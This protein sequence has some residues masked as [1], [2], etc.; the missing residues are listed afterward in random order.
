MLNRV[1]ILLKIQVVLP[2]G[3]N[4][5]RVPL[6]CCFSLLLFAWKVRESLFYLWRHSFFNGE[7]GGNVLSN[8]TLATKCG[9]EF[10][11]FSL[12]KYRVA[13]GGCF[14]ESG[15]FGQKQWQAGGRQR[16]YQSDT[17]SKKRED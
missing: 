11:P 17:F 3:G 14:L 2:K 10:D 4:S 12:K 15:L 13:D 7:R 6:C 1:L 16:S 5:Y 8:L 9:F